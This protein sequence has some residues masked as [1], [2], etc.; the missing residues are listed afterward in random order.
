MRAQLQCGFPAEIGADRRTARVKGAK[1]DLL[2]VLDA[3]GIQLAG[4]R[5]R[6]FSKEWIY[7]RK[8]R[9]WHPLRGEW[10][11]EGGV[12]C[13]T[14]LQPVA[15]GAEGE[16]VRIERAKEALAVHVGASVLHV[17]PGP[18]GDWNLGR[19]AR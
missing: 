1:G 12:P 16:P 7:F 4:A 17:A 11:C 18:D 19:P 10:E 9:A 15:A 2:A 5:R 8:D 6:A 3:P 13:V 14:V